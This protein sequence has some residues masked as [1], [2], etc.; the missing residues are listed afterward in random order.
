VQIARPAQGLNFAVSA[1]DLRGFVADVGNGK[2]ANL[3][4]QMP[5]TPPGCSGEIIFNGRT[6]SNDAG[7]KTFSMR[8]DHRADAW[9]LF[10]DDKTKP[11]EYHLD[12]DRSGRGSIVVFS[13]SKTAKWDFSLWDIFRDQT[14]AVIGRHDDGKIQPTRFEYARR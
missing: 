2:F 8:C 3:A 5:S 12:P 13:N 6:K 10:P 11:V 4:L 9:E 7:L 14:F 1:R